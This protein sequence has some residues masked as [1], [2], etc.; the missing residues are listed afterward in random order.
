MKI[1][2]DISPRAEDIDYNLVDATVWIVI[3]VVAIAAVG[4]FSVVKN[5]SAESK[6]VSGPHGE[7][8]VKSRKTWTVAYT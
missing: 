1:R 7:D 5:Y 3:D 4:I 6:Y 2:E 8:I